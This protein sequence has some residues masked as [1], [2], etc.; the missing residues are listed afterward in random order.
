METY[1]VSVILEIEAMH[2]ES[3]ENKLD[4]FLSGL[5]LKK[6][7]RVFHVSSSPLIKTGGDETIVEEG[8]EAVEDDWEDDWDELDFE[9]IG[10]EKT[11]T[12]AFTEVV[13]ESEIDEEPE[14]TVIAAEEDDGFTVLLNQINNPPATVEDDGEPW[15]DEEH[16]D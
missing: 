4:S 16:D 3:A 6:N 7:E 5:D 10:D 8:I 13:A 1:E 2:E 15:W 14:E 11:P 12:P 9:T